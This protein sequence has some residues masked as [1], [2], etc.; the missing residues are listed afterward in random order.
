V[1]ICNQKTFFF[2]CETNTFH[3]TYVESKNKFRAKKKFR[4]S[5]R[6]QRSRPVVARNKI[7]LN[8]FVKMLN[9][10]NFGNRMSLTMLY[11]IFFSELEN[12]EIF[13]RKL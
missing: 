12:F 5:R 1:K 9:D 3:I 7:T 6:C 4:L 11:L 10:L 2:A 8:F 13:L